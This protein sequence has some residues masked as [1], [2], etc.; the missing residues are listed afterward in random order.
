MIGDASRRRR[1]EGGKRALGRPSVSVEE[2]AELKQRLWVRA[3][4]RCECCGATVGP[5]DPEH[6]VMASHGGAD[7][8]NIVWLACRTCHERR[9]LSPFAQGRLMPIP[10]GNG[11]FTFELWWGPNKHQ[12][13]R[14]E[15]VKET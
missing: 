8:L 9:H 15:L 6:S 1:A 11:R 3:K 10:L 4:G 14:K 12:I 2:W 13:E 7:D 5:F